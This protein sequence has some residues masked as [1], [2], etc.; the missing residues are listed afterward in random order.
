MIKNRPLDHLGMAVDNVEAAKEV[1][2]TVLGGAIEGKVFCDGDP[3]P[4][5]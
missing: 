2:T 3:K 4:V 1:Y 5:Y